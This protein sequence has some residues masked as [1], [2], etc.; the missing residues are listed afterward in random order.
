MKT[1]VPELSAADVFR[2]REIAASDLVTVLSQKVEGQERVDALGNYLIVCALFAD[3]STIDNIKTACQ[4]GLVSAGAEPE[5]ANKTTEL[6]TSK[7][8]ISY[9]A[10]LS[11]ADK[12]RPPR[13]IRV[14]K[15][16]V[17]LDESEFIA[18]ILANS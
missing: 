13:G 18:G 1:V 3:N 7:E 6:I 16:S 9:I 14:S 10:S 8:G 12:S 11:Y 2:S 4:E 5:V 17:W 15:K